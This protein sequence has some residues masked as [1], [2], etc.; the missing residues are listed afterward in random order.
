M[1]KALF[2]AATLV[3]AFLTYFGTLTILGNTIMHND[4]RVFFVSMLPALCVMCYGFIKTERGD[5]R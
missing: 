1:K 2:L 5:N 3:V 4:W